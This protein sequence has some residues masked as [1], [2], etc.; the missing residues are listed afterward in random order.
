MRWLL[1]FVAITMGL[2][3]CTTC[4]Y[5]AGDLALEGERC[6]AVA[7]CQ[8]TKVRAIIVKGFDP[9]DLAGAE[10]LVESLVE[11]GFPKTYR[12]ESHH[13]AFIER[14]A[15]RVL[16]EQPDARFVIVGS[17]TGAMLARHLACRF[18]SLG[19][20]VDA[21]IEIAPVHP[22]L[23]GGSFAVPNGT[24]HIVVG[25]VVDMTVSAGPATEL[26][27]VKELGIWSTCSHPIVT[28]FVKDQL[29]MSSQLVSSVEDATTVTLPLVDRPAPLPGKMNFQVIGKR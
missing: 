25:R 19:A 2:T 17:G 18:S 28:E 10:S 15:R 24:K 4:H 3:G 9:L 22:R 29:I 7:A 21:L 23:L 12:I 20:S 27:I 14:E 1:P 6:P 5:R 8:R 11:S 26:R 13:A 16:S